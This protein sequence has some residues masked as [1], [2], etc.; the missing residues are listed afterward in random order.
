MIFL[1][2]PCD[3]IVFKFTYLGE[4]RMKVFFKP[5]IIITLV[6]VVMLTGAIGVG[7][8][9]HTLGQSHAA[10]FQPTPTITPSSNYAG[11]GAEGTQENSIHYQTVYAVWHVSPVTCGSKE[12]SSSSTWV[13]LAS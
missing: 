2:I 5:K 11:Y 7:L 12:N 1:Q 6:T 8:A 9:S 10:A 13:G 4:P 3:Y